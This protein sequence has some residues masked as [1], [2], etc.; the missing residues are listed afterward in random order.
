MLDLNKAKQFIAATNRR[1]VLAQNSAISQLPR[2]LKGFRGSVDD[3]KEFFLILEGARTIE[4]LLTKMMQSSNAINWPGCCPDGQVGGRGFLITVDDLQKS[5]NAM[6]EL[7][8][9]LKQSL[10]DECYNNPYWQPVKEEFEK[11]R[12]DA[13]E[14]I[15]DTA[16]EGELDDEDM[17]TATKQE[18]V[19][20][21][22]DPVDLLK[23]LAKTNPD[24]A[25]EGID[26]LELG[27]KEN[28]DK[29]DAID[30]LTME[31]QDDLDDIEFEF[32][33]P[34]LSA[35]ASTILNVL[36]KA[37][38]KGA[39]FLSKEELIWAIRDLGKKIATKQI[40]AVSQDLAKEG[41]I[42]VKRGKRGMAL[43]FYID[44]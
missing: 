15:E 25:E 20:T 13:R 6:R 41:K 3:L 29:Q 21:I 19:T 24:L 8:Y 38:K 18:E 30:E 11:L 5:L 28:S 2:I 4:D 34:P 10:Y 37:N 39:E 32:Q 26:V 35:T 44:R 27:L 33:T 12:A 40:I 36:D 1:L 16:E 31:F 22:K 7:V 42:K 9:R 43:G 14:E 23:T 17:D